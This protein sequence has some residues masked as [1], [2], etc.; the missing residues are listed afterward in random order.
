MTSYAIALLHIINEKLNDKGHG[1]L[2][3]SEA[4]ELWGI[5]EI[6]FATD[7]EIQ[8]WVEYYTKE[9]EVPQGEEWSAFP[10]D[11]RMSKN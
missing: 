3:F 7:E 5:S 8:G 6:D 10:I 1:K 11:L 2:S 4:D 9:E